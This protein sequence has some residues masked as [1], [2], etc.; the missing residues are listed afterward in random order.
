MGITFDGV[1][2][3]DHADFGSLQRGFD[4]IEME[5]LNEFVTDTYNEFVGRVAEG[6][7]MSI[8]DVDSLARGRVWIGSDAVAN[9]LVDEIGSLNDAIS[10]AASMAEINNYDIIELPKQKDPWESFMKEFSGGA[11]AKV[12]Q[13]VFG[14][15]YEWIQKA[16]QVKTMKEFRRG[17]HTK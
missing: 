12:G 7:N 1:K 9:G 15:E 14:D 2:T 8:E 16:E 5:M 4:E 6:R 13:W 11:K 17:C 3:H 10:Y